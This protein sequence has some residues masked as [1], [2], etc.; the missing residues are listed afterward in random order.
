M[1]DRP[2][3]NIVYLRI[4]N[5]YSQRSNC[6]KR[7]VGAVITENTKFVSAGY[8]GTPHGVPNCFDGGCDRCNN[9]SIKSGEKLDLCLCLHAEENA[10]L[11]SPKNSLENCILYC[12][13]K[14]C[15]GCLKR[16]IQVRIKK[17]YY[18]SEYSYSGEME[19]VYEFLVKSSN[20]QII[21]IREL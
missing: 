17:V 16:I 21:P 4:A 14:P 19:K 5:E 8:N 15:I 9:E 10:I 13:H 1:S 12:T 20:I 2:D 7:K 3:W 18:S 6:C 11:H